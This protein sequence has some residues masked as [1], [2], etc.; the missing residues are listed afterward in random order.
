MS[1]CF[2]EDLTWD[3]RGLEEQFIKGTE[4]EEDDRELEE[5]KKLTET[6]E[7]GSRVRYLTKRRER[8][9]VEAW[10]KVEKAIKHWDGFFRNHNKY[11]YV[12]KVVHPSLEGE[13]IR[14][15]CKG[16]REQRKDGKMP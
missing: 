13:P 1:G 11:F 8:R 12:G 9:R 14:P 3:L 7:N 4:R 2:A 16:Q 5:I 15:Q 10:G 6:R